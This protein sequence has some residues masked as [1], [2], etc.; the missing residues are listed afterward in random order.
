MIKYEVTYTKNT[1]N[2]DSPITQQINI[3][4][5]TDLYHLLVWAKNATMAIQHA[6]YL[7]ERLNM[8][9]FSIDRADRNEEED[10]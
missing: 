6:M 7:S 5:E 4:D 10:D 9:S 2:D 1:D 3:A 8:A